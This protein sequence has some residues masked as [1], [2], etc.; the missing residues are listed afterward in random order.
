MVVETRPEKRTQHDEAF[1]PDALIREARR[2]QRRR[3]LAVAVAV[4]LAA[5]G[6][7]VYA[8][9][10]A[11]GGG[12]ASIEH[13]P[14]GPT[15]NVRAFRDHGRLAFISGSTLWLLDGAT[16]KLHKLPTPG[17]GF[18][19]VQPVFS[20]DGKWLA[21]LEQRQNPATDQQYARLWIAHADGTDAHVV[22]HLDVYS[23]FGWSPTQDIV[24]VAAGPMRTKQPCP[25]YS[26]TT[27]RLVSSDG[28]TRIRATTSWLYGAA[29]SP[30]GKQIA[31]AAISYP[32]S[33]IVVYPVAGGGSGKTW[34]ALQTHQHLNGMHDVLVDL[35]GWWPKLGIGFWTFGDGMIHNNDET[36]LDL[37]PAPNAKPRTLAQTLSDGTTEVNSANSRGQLAVVADVSHGR[38]GGRTYWDK[39]QVQLCGG[40]G[41]CQ[42]LLDRKSKV[43]LDP[44]WSP[45]GDTLAF[46]EAP[47]YVNAGWIQ[48]FMQRWYGEHELL[49]YSSATGKIRVVPS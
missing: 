32:V 20:A 24:A 7:T 18:T 48:P 42:P 15:V 8:V 2:R 37:V 13:V 10:A 9:V 17:G 28:R 36:P 3:R 35:A 30:N 45:N 44:A 47:D 34:L 46:I 43:T 40:S 27:L 22:P 26:P 16:G 5:V 38:N 29:W 14:N 33:K 25:C 49:L 31:V 12:P 6:A 39:K 4:G 1:D 19:P 11:G 23:L 21:Y 41:R